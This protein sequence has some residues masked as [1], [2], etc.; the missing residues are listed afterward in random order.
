MPDTLCPLAR[1][2]ELDYLTT[3]SDGDYCAYVYHLQSCPACRS[4]LS[5][6]AKLAAQPVEEEYAT[7][8]S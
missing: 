2:L 1:Q 7:W 4:H 3:G 8:E 5:A 6:M